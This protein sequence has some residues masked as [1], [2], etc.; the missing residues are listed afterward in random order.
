MVLR[1]TFGVRPS[2]CIPNSSPLQARFM[3][4]V[5]MI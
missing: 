4:S 2:T 3:K 5:P 1:G